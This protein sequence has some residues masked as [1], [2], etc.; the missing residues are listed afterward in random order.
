[1]GIPSLSE[2]IEKRRADAQFCEHETAP[3]LKALL[4]APQD[5]R[6]FPKRP[7]KRPKLRKSKAEVKQA[8][9]YRKLQRA[10]QLRE[11][12]EREDAEAQVVAAALAQNRDLHA[13]AR[14]QAKLI[15]PDAPYLVASQA[16]PNNRRDDRSF[17]ELSVEND[18][19]KLL[20][21]EQAVLAKKSNRSG[22]KRRGGNG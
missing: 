17:S 22:R 13:L 5:P 12:R 15:G 4:N 6:K 18:K 21:R 7:V 8:A 20:L 10:K 1:M 14:R 11:F 19:L 3:D 16:Q 2:D 9:K